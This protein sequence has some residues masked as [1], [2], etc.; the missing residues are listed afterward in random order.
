MIDAIGESTVQQTARIEH[1]QAENQ[2]A[3]I[4]NETERMAVERPVE[5]ASEG[6]DAKN[7]KGNDQSRTRYAIDNNKLIIEQYGKNGELLLQ[8]PAVHSEDA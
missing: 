6:D 5:K 8:L 7:G 2:K 3:V 1:N 4:A